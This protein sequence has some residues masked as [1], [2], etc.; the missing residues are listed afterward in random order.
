MG[1][2]LGAAFLLG[3]ALGLLW[4]FLRPLGKRGDPLFVLMTGAGLCWLNFGVCGGDLRLG[5]AAAMLPGF[6]AA[7]KSLGAV[8]QPVFYGFWSLLKAMAGVFLSVP[9]KIFKIAKNVFASAG[10]WVTIGR[11][12]SLNRGGKPNARV[13]RKNRQHQDRLEPLNAAVEGPDPQSGGIFHAGLGGPELGQAERTVPNRGHP[14]SGRSDRRAESPPAGA[15]DRHG[16]GR[17]HPGHCLRGAGA[18]RPRRGHHPARQRKLK[19]G[20]STPL[21]LK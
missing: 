21:R 8:L 7:D 12:N 19:T 1:T 11:K 2:M 3:A 17:G 10:K 18:C 5:C 13:V 9:K 15:P 6:W 4:G 14:D 16:V 20:S